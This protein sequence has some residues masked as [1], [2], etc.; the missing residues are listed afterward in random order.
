MTYQ[1]YI[2][3]NYGNVFKIRFEPL[4]TVLPPALS[5][6]ILKKKQNNFGGNLK[7]R[8]CTDLKIG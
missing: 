1:T 3:S 7:M 4:N 5:K 8:Y 2:P 6:G